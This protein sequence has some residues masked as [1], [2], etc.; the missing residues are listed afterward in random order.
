[1]AGQP[2]SLFHEHVV[3]GSVPGQ[4]EISCFGP[5]VVRSV[6]SAHRNCAEAHLAYI[7][8]FTWLSGN[9]LAQKVDNA[10]NI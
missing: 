4:T 2:K 6:N 9:F 5:T 8:L 3:S 7:N 10:A 1:M